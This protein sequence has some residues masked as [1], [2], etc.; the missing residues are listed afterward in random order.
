MFQPSKTTIA[1]LEDIERRI[2]PE[3]EEDF[4]E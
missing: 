2:D 3:V 1:M 4:S